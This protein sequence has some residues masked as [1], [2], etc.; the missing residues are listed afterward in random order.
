MVIVRAA[1]AYR[2]EAADCFFTWFSP[3]ETKK[4]RNKMMK[5]KE[6]I[7]TENEAQTSLPHHT[8][9]SIIIHLISAPPSLSLLNNQKD[10]SVG[11]RVGRLL[12]L[13]WGRW[14]WWWWG[15]FCLKSFGLSLNAPF[16][17]HSYALISPSY[18]RQKTTALFIYVFNSIITFAIHSYSLSF[19]T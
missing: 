14:W 2:N 10:P 5:L 7:E 3:T 16:H 1:W 4:E 17:H 13:K 9:S 11:E 6:K 18:P 12:N 8:P 15:G 19:I